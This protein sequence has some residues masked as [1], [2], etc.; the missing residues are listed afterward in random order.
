I[1][2]QLRHDH[3]RPYY[4][5][6]LNR[7]AERHVSDSFAHWFAYMD[8]EAPIARFDRQTLRRADLL[9]FYGNPIGL[10]YSVNWDQ[11]LDGA[12]RWLEGEAAMAEVERLGL[13]SLP[14]LLRGRELAAMV[15][16]AREATQRELAQSAPSTPE[17]ALAVLRADRDFMDTLREVRL[18]RVDL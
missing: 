10:D 2:A 1:V 7:I 15:L 3:V 13:T 11:V 6:A 9:R 18:L 12:E 4:E 14:V 17:E 5:E 8:F 16:R